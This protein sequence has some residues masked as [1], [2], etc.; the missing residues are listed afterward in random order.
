M[1]GA[2]PSLR[3]DPPG[4]RVMIYTLP[5]F[6]GGSALRRGGPSMGEALPSLRLDPPGGRVMI[7]TLP[8]F[9]GGS[10]LSEGRASHESLF[11]PTR[12]SASRLKSLGPRRLTIG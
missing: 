12:H 2:L 5:R 8:R 3:L 11:V 9:V 10:S 4:G 6:V 1:G 7:Y